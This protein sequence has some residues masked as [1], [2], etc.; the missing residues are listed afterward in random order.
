VTAVRGDDRAAA[1]L[2]LGRRDCAVLFDF[3]RYQPDVIQFGQAAVRGG[4]RVVLITDPWLSPLAAVATA[5]LT[6]EVTAPSP[7]DSLVPALAVAEALIAAAVRELGDA[8]R[9]RI[10]AYDAYW[11]QRHGIGAVPAQGGPAAADPL[12]GR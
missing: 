11:A 8:P 5:V 4:A 2:D 1:S 7:F 3:R 12:P 10:A 9:T 6:A